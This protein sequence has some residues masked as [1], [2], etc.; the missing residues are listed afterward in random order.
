MQSLEVQF[1]SQ[2]G[3]KKSSSKEML[4]Y[5][6]MNQTSYPTNRKWKIDHFR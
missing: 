2:V 4:K 5:L 6:S 1:F 3:I